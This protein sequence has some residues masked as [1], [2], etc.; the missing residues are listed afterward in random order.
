VVDFNKSCEIDKGLALELSGVAVWYYRCTSCGF[1]F[2]PAFDAFSAEDWRRWVYNDDYLQVDPDYSGARAE[3]NAPLVRS[4]AGQLSL[5]DPGLAAILTARPRWL[6]YGSGAGTLTG[7]LADLPIE[8]AAWDP[9]GASARPEGQFELVTA[10]EVLEHAVMPVL[11]TR[12]ALGFVRPGGALLFSTL[13]HD[14][15]RTQDMSSWYVSPRNGHCS[16][17]STRS[18]DVM[19]G[20]F[21]FQIQHLTPN[22]HIAMRG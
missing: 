20:G 2:T 19:F 3:A 7:L 10:F 6:D 4:I 17:H 12:D 8:R 16:I 11:T 1:L 21:G 9:F 18:L 13:V 14:E 5:T 22:L 15:V